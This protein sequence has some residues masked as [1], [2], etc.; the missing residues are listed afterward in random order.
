VWTIT[1]G[2]EALSAHVA[3]EPGTPPLRVLRELRALVRER[4]AIEHTTIEVDEEPRDAGCR[5]GS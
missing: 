4:F 3:I 1:S 5:P 2:F